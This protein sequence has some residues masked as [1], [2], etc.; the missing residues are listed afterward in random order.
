MGGQEGMQMGR[1][2]NKSNIRRAD[3]TAAFQTYTED[4][5]MAEY[6]DVIDDNGNLTGETVA[7]EV[8]HRDGIRHRT[9]HLWLLRKKDGAL[10]ILLQKRSADKPSF[11]NCYDIS[12]AG[13]IPAGGEFASSALRE[14]KE[15]LGVE[16]QA[17]DL[18][19]CGQRK[20]HFEEIFH[21]ERFKDNQISNVYL[22]WMDREAEEFQV[23]KEELS[24]VRWFEFEECIEDV[25]NG[26]IP[27]CIYTEELEYRN[28]FSIR[29]IS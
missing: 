19:Y 6:L 20:F 12:S 27:N 22:L 14:L 17:E 5:N 9:S 13:H 7:R 4:T 11:P 10:Q 24:E 16:V 15:E 28:R 2:Q 26:T 8:A 1:L 29:S 25:K 18:V 21:G 23:Q 3:E